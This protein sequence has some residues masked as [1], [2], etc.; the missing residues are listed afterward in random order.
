VATDCPYGA[1][2]Q[3]EPLARYP[4][5]GGCGCWT[6]APTTC[7]GCW[8]ATRTYSPRE[9]RMLPPDDPRRQRVRDPR[10]EWRRRAGG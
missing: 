3:A 7:L 10:A 4:C 1:P 2:V 8:L 5:L 6:I 9:V